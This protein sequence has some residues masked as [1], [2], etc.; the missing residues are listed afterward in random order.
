[1]TL[2]HN[3]LEETMALDAAKDT[4]WELSLNNYVH[5]CVQ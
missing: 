1:M 4:P 5:E 3:V 2:S